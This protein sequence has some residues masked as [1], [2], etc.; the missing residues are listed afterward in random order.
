MEKS[1]DWYTGLGWPLTVMIVAGNGLVIYLIS[2]RKKLRTTTNWF[3]L[4]LAVADISFGLAFFPVVAAC[5]HNKLC[6]T[7]QQTTRFFFIYASKTNLCTLTLDRYSAIVKPFR[8]ATL[9]TMKR[10]VVLLATAWGTT[11]LLTPLFYFS[12]TL[13]APVKTYFE[14]FSLA[15]LSILQAFTIAALIFAT[16]HILL[17]AL[18]HARQNAAL[19]AQ[20]KFNHQI[21][22]SRVFKPQEA[23]SAKV[24]VIV[25]VVFI[26]S[27]SV[28]LCKNF[29]FITELCKLCELCE[30]NFQNVCDLLFCINCAVNPV[31]Y[32]FFKKD[33]RVELLRLFRCCTAHR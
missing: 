6:T 3:V 16:S 20:L 29:C 10:V 13:H 22:H 7:V 18:R 8:H 17:T 26:L 14:K 15:A 12:L 27:R 30:N 23:A 31:A 9:M 28:Y 24:V 5:N 19:L 2:T 4:S 33:I 21:Q 32:A 25:V 1:P 11:L